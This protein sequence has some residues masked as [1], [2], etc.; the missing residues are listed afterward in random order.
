MKPITFIFFSAVCLIGTSCKMSTTAT[1]SPADKAGKQN[2]ATLDRK[3]KSSQRT[4]S[5][6]EPQKNTAV[7]IILAH[8]VGGDE[9]MYIS[10]QMDAQAM[11]M[12]KEKL[13]AGQIVRIGEGIKIT[14]DGSAMFAKNTYILT[15][16]A[17]KDL[18]RIA[19]TLTAYNNTKLIIEGHTDG[20]GSEKTNLNISRARAQAVAEFLSAE[21]FDRSKIEVLPYGEQQ[22]LFS[23]ATEEGRRQNRR[24]EIIIIADE[25]LRDLAKKGS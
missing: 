12:G 2:T 1:M 25:N 4:V 10:K 16:A 9:G 21:K 13:A 6:G 7:A 18:R 5:S 22:P 17:K 20:T 24:I 15:E 19:A 11:E 23:N 14:Y 3:T 8:D